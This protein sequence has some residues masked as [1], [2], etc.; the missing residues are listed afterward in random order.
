MI[1][2]GDEVILMNLT[3]HDYSLQ[4]DILLEMARQQ[5]LILL[6]TDFH[7]PL[8]KKKNHQWDLVLD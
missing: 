1:E 6:M 3:H 4:L 7:L 8:Q 5:D 2:K